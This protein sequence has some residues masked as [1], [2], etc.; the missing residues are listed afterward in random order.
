[1]W[2]RASPECQQKQPN[3]NLNPGRSMQ[4]TEMR[5]FICQATQGCSCRGQFTITTH[6]TTVH[7]FHL[8]NVTKPHFTSSNASTWLDKSFYTHFLYCEFSKSFYL[9]TSKEQFSVGLKLL[10]INLHLDVQKD[11]AWSML[12]SICFCPFFFLNQ[13]RTF[14][15]EKK[16]SS[17]KARA[18]I[19]GMA[20]QIKRLSGQTTFRL[21]EMSS[22][23]SKAKVR[24]AT[25]EG[26]TAASLST[27]IYYNLLQ[28]III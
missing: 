23:R 10:K 26:N 17:T 19:K 15:A 21:C 27:T 11:F 8:P 18:N 5:C 25:L 3:S 7:H 13:F 4:N 9:E 1:M 6:N 2:W 16:K 28:F 12:I 22:S 20:S 14:L 24:I